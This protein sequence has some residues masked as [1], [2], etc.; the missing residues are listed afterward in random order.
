MSAWSPPGKS[1]R[2]IE[3]ANSTSPEKTSESMS[4]SGSYAVRNIVEPGVWPGA[5]TAAKVSPATSTCDSCTSSR[6]SSGSAKV[7]PGASS[8]SRA[9]VS[10]PIA[11][12][13]SLSSSRSAECTQQAACSAAHS[14][15]TEKVWSR[16]PWVNSTATGFSRCSVTSSATPSSASIPGSITTHSAPA[17]VATT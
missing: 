11:R 6:T 12:S 5:C 17:P 14:G 13:G 4:G 7:R 16:W 8:S 1:V 3:P 9:R 2:P 10:G 15:V